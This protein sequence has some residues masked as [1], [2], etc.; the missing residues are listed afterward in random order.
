VF[1]TVRKA[2]VMALIISILCLVV[3]AATTTAPASK[4]GALPS[5][6][7]FGIVTA[8]PTLNQVKVSF[9]TS[10]PT[11]AS[12][13]TSVD[14]GYEQTVLDKRLK[15]VHSITIPENPAATYH[16]K[17]TATPSKGKSSTWVGSFTTGAIGS[18]PAT[19]TSNG[20]KLL[21]N[22]VPSTL[23][24]VYGYYCSTNSYTSSALSLGAKVIQEGSPQ[25]CDITTLHAGLG[26]QVWWY[27]RSPT[28]Q[29]QLAGLP[30]LLPV[31]STL[32][33]VADPGWGCNRSSDTNFYNLVKAHS[34]QQ[35]VESV[36]NVSENL[37]LRHKNCLSSEDLHSLFWTTFAASGMGVEYYAHGATVD[38]FSVLPTIPAQASA[39]AARLATLTSGLAAGKNLVAKI[40]PTSAVK[41]RTWTYGGVIYVIAVNTGSSTTSASFTIPNTKSKTAVGLWGTPNLAVG[42]DGT[43]KASFKPL[44]V[45]FWK[46]LPPQ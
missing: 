22:G 17:V 33:L 25:P 2:H 43:T 41:L 44:G 10:S 46:L 21:L 14:T 7:K 11:T 23:I 30:E 29:Q 39:D 24:M 19:V 9:T 45:S 42:K 32:R 4:A 13:N 26:N 1:R 28:D 27:S 36:L 31:T 20:N 16:I 38:S 34:A 15:K 8:C 3:A 37:D 40:D 35:P 6:S 18:V 5:C 12:V